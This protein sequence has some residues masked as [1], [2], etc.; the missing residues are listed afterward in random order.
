MIF[1]ICFLW[2]NPLLITRVVSLAGLK[3][4]FMIFFICFLWGNLVLITRV[5]SLAGLKLGFMIF[6]SLI[7]IKLSQSYDSRRRFTGL[8]QYDTIFFFTFYCF[9]SLQQWAT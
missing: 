1:V 7:S 3:L 4:N 8:T 9:F 6:F 5:V 2:G